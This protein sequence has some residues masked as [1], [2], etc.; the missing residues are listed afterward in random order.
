[1][2]DMKSQA[3]F[4]SIL[5][6][7]L[8]IAITAPMDANGL[9]MFSALPLL[10]LAL[11]LWW[12]QRLSHVRVGLT[13]GRPI[14]YVL[15]VAYPLIIL[16]LGA[17]IAI[18]SG[19]AHPGTFGSSNI[20]RVLISASVG[21][22]G[23]LLTEE[24]FFRGWLWG[25]LES[26][27]LGRYRVLIVTSLAFAAW[28]I[29]Y[30]TLANGYILPPVQVV[31]FIANAAVMGAIWGLLRLISRSIIVSS[32]SHSV[33]NAIAY[34]LF[35]EGP[36]I[37]LL[38]VTQTSLYGAEVGVIGLVLNCIFALTLFAVHKN[39]SRIGALAQR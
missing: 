8:A 37:G 30:A 16:G 36:K 32:V 9:T 21:I 12:L 7:V 26:T 31:I 15:A 5:G 4:Y 6:F 18:L 19:A 20:N 14:D 24:G 39:R 2:A 1:M 11:G 35:G 33:W 29:S 28:H 22:L 34:A 10:P 3:L 38:G 23:V 13:L 17:S 27:D 25:S